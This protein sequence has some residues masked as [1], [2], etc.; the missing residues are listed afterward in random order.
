MESSSFPFLAV[1][2]AV[3]MGMGVV[4]LI[5]ALGELV[6][7][8][9]AAQPYWLHAAWLCL[10]LLLYF[11]VWWSFWEFRLVAHWT[12]L[13]YL[14]LLTGPVALFAATSLLA[15]DLREPS[16]FDSR[17]HYYAV[18]R[19]F[20]AVMSVAVA[21]GASIYPVMFGTIDPILEWLLLFLAVMVTLAITS[22]E[23]AHAVLT[24]VAWLMFVIFVG[25]YGFVIAAA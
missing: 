16:R 20:F 3:L 2:F 15:P 1:M 25:S 14:F 18:H 11:H 4:Q 19:A 21:W 13:K 10:L 12:Y 7:H 23:R 22:N 6:K 9:R 24:V 8:R 5:T 17:R